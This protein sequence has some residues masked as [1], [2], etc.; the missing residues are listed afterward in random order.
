M[1]YGQQRQHARAQFGQSADRLTHVVETICYC[2]S[3]GDNHEQ[4]EE[5]HLDFAHFKVVLGTLQLSFEKV[6]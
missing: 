3:V 1:A 6:R 2:S 5:E 4:C